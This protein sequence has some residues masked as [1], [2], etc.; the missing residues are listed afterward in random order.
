MDFEALYNLNA[1]YV[2]R[3]VLSLCKNEHTAEE[4]TSETFYKAICSADKFKG[5]CSVHVWLCQ[6]AKN[7]Y[8]NAAKKNKFTTELPDDLPSEH[9][10][11][12]KLLNKSQALEIHKAL[13]LLHEPYKEVFSLRLF[14]ELSFSEIG[15]IF[16]KSENWA[17]VTF[18]RAKNKIKEEMADGG[19]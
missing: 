10:F 7:S 19:L 18:Y 6:I 8:Y 16:G 3:Y 13:H 12:D 1:K 11:E 15:T 5:D 4:I 9:R 14:S 17:R 2:Y